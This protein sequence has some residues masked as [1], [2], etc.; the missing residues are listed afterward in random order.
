MAIIR[1]S[2][3]EGSTIRGADHGASISL[4]LDRSA[5]GHGPRLHRHTYDETWVVQ[6]GSVTFTAGDET[7]QA[8]PGDVVVVPAGVAHKFVND[9][10]GESEMVCIHASPTLSTEWLE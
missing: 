6:A 8:G 10:P 2:E 4:I 5:P 1:A 7:H 9:G 3:R